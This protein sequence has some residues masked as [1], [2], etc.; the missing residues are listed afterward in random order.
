MEK[1]REVEKAAPVAR[2]GGRVGGVCGGGGKAFVEMERAGG[3]KSCCCSEGGW[4][5][6]AG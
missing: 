6:C 2:A 4:A 3:G 5:V 1:G